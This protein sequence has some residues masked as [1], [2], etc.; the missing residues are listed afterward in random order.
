[1]D[2]L[3]RLRTD[4]VDLYLLHRDDP[5][6]PVAPIIDALARHQAGGRIHA[7]GGSNWSPAR[8]RAANEYAEQHGL[9]PLRA[10]SPNFSLAVQRRAPWPECLSISGPAGAAD[11]AWYRRAE[12]PLHGVVE[13]GRRLLLWAVAA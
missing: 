7:C 13:P 9:P 12:M 5:E 4:Y 8:I 11:R 10:S 2:S 1:M 6:L 3:A